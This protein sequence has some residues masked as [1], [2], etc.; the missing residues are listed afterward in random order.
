MF[1]RRIYLTDTD[2]AIN[3]NV[4][5]TNGKDD[6]SGE[7]TAVIIDPRLLLQ[8]VEKH[9]QGYLRQLRDP[10]NQELRDRFISLWKQMYPD[11]RD[12]IELGDF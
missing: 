12:Y 6:P 2:A 1:K 8:E 9:F 3:A 10:N 5:K 4:K 11:V 7:I